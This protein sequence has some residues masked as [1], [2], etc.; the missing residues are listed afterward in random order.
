MSG[1]GGGGGEGDVQTIQNNPC[2]K[3]TQPSIRKQLVIILQFN[4]K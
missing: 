1:G 4:K 3:C 2:Q